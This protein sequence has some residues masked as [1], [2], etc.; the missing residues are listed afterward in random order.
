VA[1]RAINLAATAMKTSSVEA[2]T[3]TGTIAP[4]ALGGKIRSGE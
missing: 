2:A 3:A 1:H 4:L